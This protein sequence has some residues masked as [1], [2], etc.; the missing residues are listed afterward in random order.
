VV[1][2]DFETDILVRIHTLGDPTQDTAESND[3][4][5]KSAGSQILTVQL[6]AKQSDL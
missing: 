4:V 2:K 1:F 3:T 6:Q 5:K